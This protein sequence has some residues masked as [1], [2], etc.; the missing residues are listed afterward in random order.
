MLITQS[1]MISECFNSAG[2]EMIALYLL[3]DP[4]LLI[5]NRLKNECW[6]WEKAFHMTSVGETVRLIAGVA[7]F[8]N[9]FEIFEAII[10]WITEQME[11][12]G[13]PAR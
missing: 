3:P 11:K 6:D 10:Q 1:K 8:R 7:F 12:L 13:Y 2:G 4:Q 9:D 5:I